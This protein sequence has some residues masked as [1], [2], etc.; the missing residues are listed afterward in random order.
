MSNQFALDSAIHYEPIAKYFNW[1][2]LNT[3]PLAMSCPICTTG[4][5]GIYEDP[6]TGGYWTACGR[7]EWGDS[8]FRL[9]QKLRNVHDARSAWLQLITDTGIKPPAHLMSQK[10]IDLYESYEEEKAIL[11]RYWNKATQK[12]SRDMP[13]ESSNLMQRNITCGGHTTLRPLKTD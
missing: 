10:S 9:Y 5:M 12:L 11:K 1:R 4:R 6:E 3:H 2:I 8:L 7:C 13:S